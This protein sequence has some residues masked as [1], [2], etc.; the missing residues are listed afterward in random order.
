VCRIIGSSPYLRRP[1]PAAGLCD[2]SIRPAGEVHAVSVSRDDPTAAEPLARQLADDL[3]RPAICARFAL[4]VIGAPAVNAIVGRL[5]HAE[6]EVRERGP[7]GAAREL[8]LIGGEAAEPLIKAL[9]HWDYRVRANAARA[10]G[11]IGLAKATDALTK[12]L[13]GDDDGF[14]RATAAWSLGRIG[15][16]RAREALKKAVSDKHGMVR[17]CA[18]RAL[19]AMENK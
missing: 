9:A 19:P 13:A 8:A 2:D 11:H 15:D 6:P 16:P 12:T 5:A 17:Q 3:W 10:L 14:V 1:A 18:R 7:A 4:E